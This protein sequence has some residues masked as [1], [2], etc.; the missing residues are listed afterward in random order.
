M[1]VV[2]PHFGTPQAAMTYLAAAYNRYDVA[3]LHHVTTP[4]SFKELMAMRS[5]AVNLQLKSCTPTGHGDYSCVFRHRYPKRMH[6]SGYGASEMI[7][8]PARN[9]GWYMYAL[10]GCG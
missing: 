1:S 9:P 10:A 6:N 2:G 3:A 7:A 8:A 4:S 5:E